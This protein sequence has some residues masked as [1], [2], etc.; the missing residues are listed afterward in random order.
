MAQALFDDHPLGEYL[1]GIYLLL[2]LYLVLTVLMNRSRRDIFLD[3][4]NLIRVGA[5]DRPKLRRVG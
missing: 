1:R 3:S 2:K 4:W 5:R